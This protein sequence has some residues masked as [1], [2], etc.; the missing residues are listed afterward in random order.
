MRG[1]LSGLELKLL[2]LEFIIYLPKLKVSDLGPLFQYFSNY[3]QFL[4]LFSS[5]QHYFTLIITNYFYKLQIFFIKL[6]DLQTLSAKSPGF[7]R[8]FV[9]PKEIISFLRPA[10]G[11]LDSTSGSLGTC[12]VPR[13]PPRFLCVTLV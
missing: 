2:K 9:R 6:I 1:N 10:F 13:S 8:I 12:S 7:A 3:F 11:L 4:Y 5:P